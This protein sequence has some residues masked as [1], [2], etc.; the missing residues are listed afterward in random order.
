MDSGTELLRLLMPSMV[1]FGCDAERVPEGANIV[2]FVERN[3]SDL[4]VIE[5]PIEQPS[6]PAL[7]KSIR[8]RESACR[9]AAVLL[10]TGRV[11]RR[12]AEEYLNRGVNRVIL[13]EATD[14]ELESAIGDLLQVEPRVPL[15]QSVRLE[16]PL[17]GKSERVM[18][19]IDNVS[20]SG[21]LIRGRWDVEIG[22]PVAF[23]F[24]PPDERRS[25]RGLAEVVRPT[26]RKREGLVGYGLQFVRLENDG[27]QRLD[28]FIEQQRLL[29][30]VAEAEPENDA[31][32]TA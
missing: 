11:P 19:Q 4:I 3:V 1:R 18:A 13:D 28:R 14:W 30:E 16:L 15:G 7:L 6:L 26:V 21:M 17:A 12:L 32:E 29:P 8:W 24:T 27:R 22:A 31:A 2:E 23:E 9:R 10:V 5:F 25:I 20:S